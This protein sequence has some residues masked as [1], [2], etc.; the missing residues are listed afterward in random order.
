MTGLG[1]TSGVWQVELDS[2]RFCQ[3]LKF[4]GEFGVDCGYLCAVISRQLRKT[5]SS[6][7]KWTRRVRWWHTLRIWRGIRRI[8]LSGLL[9]LLEIFNIL[10]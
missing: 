7:E 9:I 1:I 4:L 3:S 10:F 8:S 5:R 2:G 6:K